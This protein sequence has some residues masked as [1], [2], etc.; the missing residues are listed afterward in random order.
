MLQSLKTPC[1]RVTPLLRP[2]PLKG[3]ISHRY[4]EILDTFKVQ[5]LEFSFW[6]SSTRTNFLA[7]QDPSIISLHP[8]CMPC[9]RHPGTP[10]FSTTPGVSCLQLAVS[11]FQ[12]AAK[13]NAPLV[14]LSMWQMPP[15]VLATFGDSRGHCQTLTQP[16]SPTEESLVQLLTAGDHLPKPGHALPI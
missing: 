1:I 4:I 2:S 11:C 3:H 7:F 16:R 6:V 9:S 8:A 13:V 15:L 5:D 14:L 10:T 12:L